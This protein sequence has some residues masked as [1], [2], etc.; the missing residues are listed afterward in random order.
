MTYYFYSAFNCK[1]KRRVIPYGNHS[2]QQRS[3]R[4]QKGNIKCTAKKHP[5]LSPMP[6]YS[7]AFL[8]TLLLPVLLS[9][10]D[11]ALTSHTVRPSVTK[12]PL[13]VGVCKQIGVHLL[14]GECSLITITAETKHDEVIKAV[15]V[16]VES[17]LRSV[18]REHVLRDL[19]TEYFCDRRQVFCPLWIL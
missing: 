4:C 18:D 10:M 6:F 9:P 7:D 16:L 15:N 1:H 3:L 8:V 14:V 11:V 5:S 12:L 17:N 19:V 2:Q 13:T